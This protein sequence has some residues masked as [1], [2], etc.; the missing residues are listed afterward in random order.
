MQTVDPRL[1]WDE[2]LAAVHHFQPTLDTK[3]WKA[4]PDWPLLVAAHEPT[5]ALAFSLCNYPQLVRHLQPLLHGGNLS[6]L[7]PSGSRPV[8]A[9]ELASWAEE[10]ARKDRFPQLL[11]ALGALRLA[12]QFDLADSLLLE[13]RQGT[14]P[15]WQ[16]A[17]ANEEASLAWHRGQADQPWRFGW[18]KQRACRFCLIAAWLRCSWT[19]RPR[20]GPRWARQSRN[21]RKP[22][23]GI[24]WAA[25]ISPW[26]RWRG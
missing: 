11:L 6:Q 20:R 4:P 26:P 3:S 21:C 8:H 7:R 10:T 24:T 19:V 1:V 17:L 2:A 12:R 16:A 18:N 22:E 13:H 15:M 14:P 5:V 23:P 9:P 25:S